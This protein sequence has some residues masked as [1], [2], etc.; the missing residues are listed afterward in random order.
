MMGSF[1]PGVGTEMGFNSGFNQPP[2][3][4]GF[5]MP[6]VGTEMGINAPFIPGVGTEMG[7]APGAGGF[8]SLSFPSV[9]PANLPG[10]NP[11]I[12]GGGQNY[13]YGPGQTP[14]YW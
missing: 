2:M 12:Q 4:G 9:P 14:P 7:L 5:M 6:G 3:G 10:F 13:G 11:N 8:N 1:M